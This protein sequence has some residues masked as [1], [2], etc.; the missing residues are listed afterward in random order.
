MYQKLNEQFQIYFLKKKLANKVWNI[1]N[2]YQIEIKG[3]I[4][5]S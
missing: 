2:Y 4:M 3:I 5:Y 1:I